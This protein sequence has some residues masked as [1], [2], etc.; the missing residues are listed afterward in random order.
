MP[1]N[2]DGTNGINQS[3]VTGSTVIPTGTTAQRPQNPVDGML[4]YNTDFGGLEIY[5][6]SASVWVNA[7]NSFVSASG[8]NETDITRTEGVYRVHAFTNVGNSTFNITVG[9]YIHLLIVGGGGGG[10]YTWGSGGGAG[11]L[12]FEP[13]YYVTPGSYSITVGA[14]GT[15][16]SSTQTD[17][18]PGEN[19]SFDNLVAFGGGGGGSSGS[20]IQRDGGSGGGSQPSGS[21]REGNKTQIRGFG[22]DGSDGGGGGGARNTSF[23]FS[24]GNDGKGQDGICEAHG[25][26]FAYI[27]GTDY[28]HVVN[29]EMF[30][31]GGGH[32]AAGLDDDSFY[33]FPV[34]G[35][36]GSGSDALARQSTNAAINGSGGGGSGNNST[37]DS[38]GDGGSGIV[39][40]RYRI[41]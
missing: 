31:A 8:G 7:S 41:Q 18:Q 4:R 30:F 21:G 13:N 11:G 16:P 22:N 12:I 25:Y 19:S 15:M 17:G 23:I 29:D 39:L 36:L 28:G 9:G 34:D 26:N 35:S 40:I 1:I 32:A 6:A 24:G 37:G 20:T 10:G 27:Y 5:N 33:S 14:G 3:A 38:N 2:I